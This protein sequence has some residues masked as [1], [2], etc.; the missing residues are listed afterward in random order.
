MLGLRPCLGPRK[1]AA[2]DSSY[3]VDECPAVRSGG[4]AVHAEGEGQQSHGE[5]DAAVGSRAPGD[6]GGFGSA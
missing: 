5:A 3:V 4:R 6:C 2:A 1:A